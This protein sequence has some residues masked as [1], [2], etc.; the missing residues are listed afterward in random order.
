M[1]FQHCRPDQ[2]GNEMY[3]VFQSMEDNEGWLPTDRKVRSLYD[4]AREDIAAMEK[5]KD[6]KR[7]QMKQLDGVEG[8]G[9]T[10]PSVPTPQPVSSAPIVVAAPVQAYSVS[11]APV[12]NQPSWTAPVAQPVIANGYGTAGIDQT[13]QLQQPK[14]VQQD[15]GFG[16]MQQPAVQSNTMPQHASS[17]QQYTA[18][19]QQQPSVN[20]VFDP[21]DGI[22]GTA[23]NNT[24]FSQTASK[25][26][27]SFDPFS[28]GNGQQQQQQPNLSAADMNLFKY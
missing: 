7:E 22:G 23:N 15:S 26:G 21:F 24:S 1:S 10:P 14:A 4:A 17:I 11:Q 9:L 20:G 8:S 28:A 18:Q 6:E 27:N 5:A 16:F 19:P 12:D 3:P 13:T 2:F 25:G